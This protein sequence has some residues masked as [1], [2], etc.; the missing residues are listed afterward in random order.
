MGAA[1]GQE[2]GAH[3]RL[4]ICAR[5]AHLL[6]AERQLF[7]H[8]GKQDLVV[9]VLKQDADLA[10]H[11]LALARRVKPRH[12]NCARAGRN[13]PRHQPQKGGFSRPVAPQKA[14]PRFG[15]M[16]RQV[17]QDALAAQIHIHTLQHDSVHGPA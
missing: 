4:S 3:L 2:R 9:G 17:R 10:E 6:Q 13:Q 14:N 11:R 7:D 1:F 12:P 8:R 15:Q 16:Q 5:L